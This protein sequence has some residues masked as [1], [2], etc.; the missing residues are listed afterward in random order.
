MDSIYEAFEKAWVYR[1][2]I[3]KGSAELS[4]ARRRMESDPRYDARKHLEVLNRADRF[5]RDDS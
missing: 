2:T 1:V 4:E 3:R 5:V